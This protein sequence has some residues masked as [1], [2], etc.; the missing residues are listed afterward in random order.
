MNVFG[1][2]QH[3]EKYIPKVMNNILTGQ[4]TLIH[5]YKNKERAGSRFYIHARNVASAILFLFENGDIG[6]K[7]NIVGEKEI[8]KRN[9]VQG[10][11]CVQGV[12]YPTRGAL[13]YTLDYQEVSYLDTQR[14]LS[15]LYTAV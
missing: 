1:Q 13:T 5:S 6:D 9:H 14:V 3:P 4:K 12:R 8:D 2:R 15:D 11:G 10:S 7:Y